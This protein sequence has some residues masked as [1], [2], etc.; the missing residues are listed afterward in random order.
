[1]YELQY[2]PPISTADLFN[3]NFVLSDIKTRL[4]NLFGFYVDRASV[5]GDSLYEGDILRKDE[6]QVVF[7][8]GERLDPVSI[9]APNEG[10]L[11]SASDY[12]ITDIN[13]LDAPLRV[14]GIEKVVRTADSH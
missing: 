7:H 12:P 14:L 3:R 6:V 2:G 1:M 4:M 13:S 5:S 9:S 10:K 8:F 11:A